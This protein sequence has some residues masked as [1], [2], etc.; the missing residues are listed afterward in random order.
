M[1]CKTARK[2][3]DLAPLTLQLSNEHNQDFF[4]AIQEMHSRFSKAEVEPMVVYCWMIWSARNK[5]IFEGKKFDPRISATKVESVLKAYQ[6]VRNP[7][8]I[9]ASKIK[10]EFQQRWKPP[11]EN[12]LKLN[13]DA[14]M[15]SK[16]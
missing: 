9:L 16:D 10:G 15:N 2:I 4:N 1:K 13:V 3:W 5:F 8:T 14:A 12:L 7:R 6:R 11:P